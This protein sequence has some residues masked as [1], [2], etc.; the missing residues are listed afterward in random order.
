MFTLQQIKTAHSK[1][2]SG[3]DFPNYFKEI[4]VLGVTRYET[5]VADGHTDYFGSNEYK[6]TSIPKYE[7]LDIAE[8]SDIE[9]FQNNL[10]SHQ[11]GKT[12][13]STFCIDA[14][15][16]GIEKWTVCMEKKTCTYYDKAGNELLVEQIPE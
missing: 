12:D 13:F 9:Q 2:K 6:I 8:K 7:T 16:L 5:F 3:A 1:V 11:Q 14:G 10:K 4:A 15:K